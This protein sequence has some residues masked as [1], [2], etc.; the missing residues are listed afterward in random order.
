[1]QPPTPPTR[2]LLLDAMGTLVRLDPP[3]PSLRRELAYRFGLLLS[4]A[5]TERAMGAE[6]ALYRQRMHG[7]SDPAGVQALRAAAAE[8]L[9]AAL[10]PDRRLPDVSTPEL[11][12][13]LLAS[14]HFTAY[15]DALPALRWARQRGM[16]IVVVSNWDSA[17]GE[18]LGRVGLA[19]W[20]DGVVS[21]AVAGVAKPD[22]AIFA[23]ALAE[24][25]V[26]AAEA[27]HVGDSL[28][29]DVAGA[30]AA[31]VRAVWL[32]RSGSS[33]A[34]DV[35]AISSLAELTDRL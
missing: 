30:R 22:P 19:P 21:S 33:T 26:D 15:P 34:Q 31:G 13:A 10:P 11:V 35:S 2:A 27:L 12:E 24:V 9:R 29:E 4:P 23:I 20:L 32:D 28:A 17:L 6:I 16:R 5:E 25:G 8:A 7:A 1:M 18:M 3:G 14:L